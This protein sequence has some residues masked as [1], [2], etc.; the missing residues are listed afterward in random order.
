MKENNLCLEEFVEL[1]KAQQ[2]Q[3]ALKKRRWSSD[4][5][6]EREELPWRT[7]EANVRRVVPYTPESSPNELDIIKL[8]TN[9]CPYPPAPGV[10]KSTAGV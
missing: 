5:T 1:A 4:T 2:E 8:N 6:S 7:G 9:E 3:E 10:T